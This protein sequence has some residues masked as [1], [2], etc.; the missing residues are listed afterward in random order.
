M[1][2]KERVLG[3]C[4][5][6]PFACL[7][8]V[9]ARVGVTA[10]CATTMWPTPR[11]PPVDMRNLMLD[12]SHFPD[13]WQRCIGPTQQPEHVHPEQGAAELWFVGFCPTGFNGFQQ[14]IDGAEHDVFRYRDPMEATTRFYVTFSRDEFSNRYT[15]SPWSVPEVWSYESETADRFRFAC[16]EVEPFDLGRVVTHC[17][18]LAQYSEYISVFGTT[19]EPEYMTLRDLVHVLVAVDERMAR[20][21]EKDTQ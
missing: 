11:T 14:G 3:S 12:V 17:T 16:A 9:C 15:I 2:I 19:L 10:L 20:Y 5:A 1:D 21:L 4:V 18:A 8:V 7:L 13:E 6:L